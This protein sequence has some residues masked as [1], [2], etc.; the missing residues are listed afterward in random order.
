MCKAYDALSVEQKE[1]FDNLMDHVDDSDPEAWLPIVNA[2]QEHLEIETFVQ[3]PY[4]GN[5]ARSETAD[6]AEAG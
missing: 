5:R 1:M 4:R 3:V 2:I 6:F